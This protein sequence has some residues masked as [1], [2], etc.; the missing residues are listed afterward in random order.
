MAGGSTLKYFALGVAAV[1]VVGAAFYLLST[2]DVEEEEIKEEI[3]EGLTMET[4]REMLS[5][6]IAQIKKIQK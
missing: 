2:D 4:I 3:P 1:A 6:D 5:E